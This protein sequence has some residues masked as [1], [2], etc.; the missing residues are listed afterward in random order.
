MAEH[1]D[2]K[3]GGPYRESSSSGDISK[4]RDLL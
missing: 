4:A 2:F 1:K 3:Q